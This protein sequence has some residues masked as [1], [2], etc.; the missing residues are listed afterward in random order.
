MEETFGREKE[1]AAGIIQRLRVGPNNARIAIIKF[2]AKEKVKTVWSF[3]Q[4]QVQEKVLQAL[5][6]IPFSSGTTAIHTALLQV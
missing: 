4:P 6:E 1:L 5:D 3:D 2:A